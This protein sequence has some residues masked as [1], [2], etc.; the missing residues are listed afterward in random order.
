MMNFEQFYEFIG[1][2]KWRKATTAVRNP[3]EYVVQHKTVIGTDEEFLEAVE[4]IKANGFQLV[5][6]NQYYTC[7][8]LGKRLYWSLGSNSG[9]IILNRSNM[10]DYKVTLD[11]K[12]GV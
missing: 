4:F 9:D 10:R 3:H 6:W 11:A 5:L 12:D 8:A 7:F 2:Q 1:R